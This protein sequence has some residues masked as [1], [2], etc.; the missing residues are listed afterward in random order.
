MARHYKGKWLESS[1]SKDGNEKGSNSRKG[2][3]KEL[4]HRQKSF[5][6][7]VERLYNGKEKKTFEEAEKS[8]RKGGNR[9][10]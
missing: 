2:E 3:E 7:K 1:G 6:R 9:R 5:A 4:V 10:R 8:V